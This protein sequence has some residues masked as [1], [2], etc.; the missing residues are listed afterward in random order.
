MYAHVPEKFHTMFQD[1]ASRRCSV[2][3]DRSSPGSVVSAKSRDFFNFFAQLASCQTC[4]FL[5]IPIFNHKNLV[6]GG[7]RKTKGVKLQ[8]WVFIKKTSDTVYENT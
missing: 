6:L 1:L 7:V 2:Y 8:I 5:T 3:W 4:L